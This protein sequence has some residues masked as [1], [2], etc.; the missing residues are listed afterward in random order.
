[1][2]RESELR[3]RRPVSASRE[4]RKAQPHSGFPA[5]LTLR[6]AADGLRIERYFT[7][8]GVDPFDEIEW[9]T[10]N[11][12]IANEKGEIVFEQRDVEIPKFWSQTATNVVASKYF[13]G[14]L[15]TAS[16]E[17]S[18]KQ[19]IGRVVRTLGGWGRAQGYFDSE[20]DA[21]AYEAELKHLLVY[22]KMSFNSPVW[23]NIGVESRPQCSACFINSVEDTMESILTLARTEGML[24]KYGSGTGTN[25][26]PI[27]SSKELLAGGGTA[28]GPVS[29]MKG[30]DAFAGVIKSGGKTR[31]AA[32]MVIL[33][34]DHPDVVEFIKCKQN[35]E[36]KA[37]ALIDAGYSSALDG[38]AYS[39]VFFQN[40]NNSVR[41]IDEFME[42]IIRDADWSTREVTSGKPF[43]TFKARD[44]MRM[45]AEATWACGDPGMQFDTTVNDWHPCSH[46]ARINASNPCV[47]GDTLVATA[48]GA[49][50]I[51]DLVG[52]PVVQ[53][54]GKD[55]ELVPVTEVFKTGVKPVFLLKT[56]SGYTLKVTKDHPVWTSNRGDVKAGD[57]K[58]GDH[59]ALMP[60]RFGAESIDPRMAEFIGMA[61]GDGCKSGEQGQ[62]FVTMGE[63]E[64]AV[65]AP[66][67]DYLN[68]VK[69]GW[70]ISG[71][72]RTATGVRVVSSA[73]EVVPVVD[74]YAVLDKGSSGKRFTEAAF[75]LDRETT[76]ALL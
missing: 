34:I 16:R 47:T 28:S 3:E 31:R 69:P 60:G 54:V 17:R 32:K 25:L 73:S 50:A 30:Y 23:F 70:K 33:N 12:L 53:I 72:T 8:P 10:R 6:K 56:H 15:G 45:I 37:W 71:L 26:S 43:E 76:A 61:V 20:A 40:S 55:G 64:E 48:E 46:T 38:P 52:R 65:L 19:L 7:R 75:R 42:A 44:L 22:Q 21:Q 41:V 29:F 36:K 49:I 2:K 67:V 5:P 51:R 57:L 27:R 9:E 68:S 18:V 11:A 13:R 74:R 63:H 4:G 58:A 35:E 59:L 39:S 66:Y 24:F 62:V 1:M 14:T